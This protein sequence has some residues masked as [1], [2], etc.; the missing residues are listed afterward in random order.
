M[1]P[2]FPCPA[3]PLLLSQADGLQR[4]DCAHPGAAA[5]QTIS[6][7]QRLTLSAMFHLRLIWTRAAQRQYPGI[8]RA[9][10]AVMLSAPHRKCR[11]QGLQ[12]SLPSQQGHLRTV[13]ISRAWE[14]S[15][16]AARQ[17]RSGT[18]IGLPCYGR[19]SREAV[20]GSLHPSCICHTACWP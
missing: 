8:A 15:S 17:Q 5:V 13:A 19:V 11:Q 16:S 4:T 14:R 18:N 9:L 12:R 6:A 3:P 7:A 10:P 1:S 2:R 20:H